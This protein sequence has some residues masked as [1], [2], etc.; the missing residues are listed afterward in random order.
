M[1]NK[2]VLGVLDHGG[3]LF[4]VDS[5]ILS[6][7]LGNKLLEVVLEMGVGALDWDGLFGIEILISKEDPITMHFPPFYLFNH[8]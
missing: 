4:M 8:I 7:E 5:D 2:I 1:E 3:D 6:I